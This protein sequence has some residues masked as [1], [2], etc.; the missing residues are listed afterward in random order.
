MPRRALVV[1]NDPFCV[2]LLSD[3]LIQAGYEVVKAYDGLEAMDALHRSHPDVVFLDMVMPKVDGDQVLR[4]IRENPATRHLPVVI[5]SGTLVEDQEKLVTLGADAYVAKGRAQDLAKH[6]VATLERLQRGESARDRQVLG[7]ENL[8]PRDKVRELLLIR[9]FRNAILRTIAEGV[10]ILDEDRRV[11]S[12]NRAALAMLGRP[13]LELLGSPVIALL[14]PELYPV[15]EE[16]LARFMATSSREIDPVGLRYRD[17]LLRM[18]FAWVSPGIP[19]DGFFLLLQDVTD[20]AGKIEELSALNAR[21]EA[22]DSLR[23]EL[24][25]MVSH[26]L[27]TPLTAI[28]GSLEVVL[29]E[30]VGVELGR[31]LLGI[32]LKNADRLF[33]LVS[34]ILDLTRI[35]SGRFAG[36]HEPFDLV[37]ALQAAVERLRPLAAARQ[38]RLEV[39][40]PQ[41]ILPIEADGVRMEQLFTNLLDNA[42]KFTPPGGTVEAIVED[43]P[44]EL[45]LG[46]RDSGVGI[47]PEH[48][49][50][51]FDRF[52]RVPQPAGSDV[53]GTG[54]GLSICKA[55]VDDHGG[56]IWVQSSPG[57]GSTFFVAIPRHGKL[58]QGQP[59][60]G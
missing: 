31:E 29:R 1:D 24:L 51:I 41:G 56:R 32:A 30:N 40:A 4:Y 18:A 16:T 33:R 37:G 50:R 3:I 28:K 43:D 12:V 57:Q 60:P 2:E 49:E 46:V 27:H 58:L 42:V 11:M 15:L 47:A 39:Q 44:G 35:E 59:D 19:S 5:V 21:L 14:G 8:V 26:D 7:L 54:L 36:R 34:D 13:E 53:D 45:V 23:S 38:I 17:R 9:R 25:A 6:V 22:M 10:V 48:L 55:V 52:Y 20:L